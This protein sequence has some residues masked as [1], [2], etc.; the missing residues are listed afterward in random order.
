M[1]SHRFAINTL[2]NIAIKEAK[3]DY[4]FPVNG[5]VLPSPNLRR[6][7]IEYA[8][9]EKLFDVYEHDY[10]DPE[11]Y[12][13]IGT[14]PIKLPVERSTMS[15]KELKRRQAFVF[16]AFETV[17][18][19]PATQSIPKTKS[20]LLQHIRL[21]YVRHFES[22]IW[23]RRQAKVNYSKWKSLPMATVNATDASLPTYTIHPGSDDEFL[24]EPFYIYAKDAPLFDERFLKPA[25]DRRSHCY[26]LT[27]LGYEFVVMPDEFVIGL[28][29]KNMQMN[30]NIA[31]AFFTNLS[32]WH[33]FE[34][35]Y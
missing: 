12:D 4:L 31:R 28:G 14:V 30:A 16:P 27:R 7:F 15:S 20:V 5:D 23:F 24:A 13:R 2:R 21:G 25:F 3:T 26:L 34:D 19:N 17:T 8:N 1:S 18:L 9:R 32:L 11:D 29:W 6:M 33:K 10:M 35:E 22:E